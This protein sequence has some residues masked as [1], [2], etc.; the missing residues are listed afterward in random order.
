MNRRVIR[1]VFRVFVEGEMLSEDN[2]EATWED[3]PQLMERLAQEHAELSQGLRTLVELEFIDE[4]PSKDRFFR[5]GND[6]SGMVCP[7]EIRLR[8]PN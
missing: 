7:M 2:V 3:M 6:P 1:I 8:K 5:L 4:Y